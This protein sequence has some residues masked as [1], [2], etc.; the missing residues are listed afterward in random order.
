MIRNKNIRNRRKIEDLYELN[1]H[2]TLENDDQLSGISPRSNLTEISFNQSYD[3]DELKNFLKDKI[4]PNKRDIVYY[5]EDIKGTK[6][7]NWKEIEKLDEIKLENSLIYL[8]SKEA[9]NCKKEIEKR[10]IN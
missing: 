8:N 7:T 4:E 1:V 3:E 9:Q 10:L 5:S 6:E 2:K